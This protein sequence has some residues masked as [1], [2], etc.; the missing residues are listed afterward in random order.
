MGELAKCQFPEGV[1]FK[2]PD[3]SGVLALTVLLLQQDGWLRLRLTSPLAI[4]VCERYFGQRQRLIAAHVEFKNYGGVQ[5]VQQLGDISNSALE[6]GLIKFRTTP[7][8][9]F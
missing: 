2:L 9:Q 4:S 5:L 3:N 6:R 1:E 8:M 7:L